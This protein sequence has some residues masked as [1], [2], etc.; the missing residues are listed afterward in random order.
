MAPARER[1]G[2]ISRGYARAIL[3]V[4]P[5]VPVAWIA[6][7]VAATLTLPSLGSAGSAPLEDLVAE[8]SPALVAQER[9]AELFGAPL[10]TD[11]VVVQ[12]D[13]AGLGPDERDA[14]AAAAG[15]EAAGRGEPGIT[16]ALPLVNLS[17]GP[18]RWNEEGTTA[19]AFL[20]FDEGLNLEER[21]AAAGRFV[22]R[23]EP[24]E[25]GRAGQTGAAPAR[26]AQ[27]EE[28]QDA[29]PIVEAASIVPDPARG[30][31]RV[32]V[33][34]RAAGRAVH[35][36][37]RIRDRDP[38]AA[39]VG[40]RSGHRPRRGRADHRRAA[41]RAGHRLLGVLP[42]RDAAPVAPGRT[43]SRGP[44]RRPAGRCRSC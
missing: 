44:R 7:L 43:G 34:R 30:R 14:F 31:D 42:E 37:D 27:Y 28:I 15:E 40:E 9:S 29:L 25:G 16:A 5:V 2:R 41:A 13:P 39:V 18:L 23:L 22:E 32:P 19:L 21:R 38:R 12:R 36:R 3:A 1:P 24:A 33:D 20:A 8:D 26:L 6:L 11:T 17:A 10:A 4:H 35:R